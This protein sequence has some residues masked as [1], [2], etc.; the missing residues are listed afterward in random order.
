MRNAYERH[1]LDIAGPSLEFD[2]V[3]ALAAAHYFFL[4]CWYLVRRDRAVEELE[5]KLVMRSPSGSP[6]QHLS[7]DLLFR[8]LPQLQRRT[9]SVDPADRLSTLLAEQLRFW[10]L[11]GVLSAVEEPPLTP[12]EFGDH[13]GL[14]LLYA[15]RWAVQRKPAWIPE[16][17]GREHVELVW[18]ELGRDPAALPAGKRGESDG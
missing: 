6:A 13:R 12:V 10:P 14:L 3:A 16:G 1:R 2:G 11:S 18:R 15:E 9:L 5:A 7:V 17:A 4:A 8:L